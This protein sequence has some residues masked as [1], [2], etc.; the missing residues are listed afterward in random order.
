MRFIFALALLLSPVMA[1]AQTAE[2]PDVPIPVQKCV[3]TTSG[4]TCTPVQDG[5]GFAA[6]DG[7]HRVRQPDALMPSRQA[8]AADV[9]R[10]PI[11]TR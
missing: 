6:A 3:R 7:Y 5:A 10:V 9:N 8:S 11:M 1:L 2:G 4:V